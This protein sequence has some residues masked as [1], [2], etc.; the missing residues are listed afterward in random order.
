M[1]LK[2]MILASVVGFSSFAAMADNTLTPSMYTCRGN[3]MSVSY[4]TSSL[5]GRPTMNVAKGTQSLLISDS[6]GSRVYAENT[7][8][9]QL[10]SMFDTRIA[11]ANRSYAL[12]IPG[13]ILGENIMEAK[14]DTML[15]ETFSGGLFAPN[16]AGIRQSNKFYRV[17]CTAAYA[18]F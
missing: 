12:V 11:D 8:M 1:N 17:R 15:I 10:V 6:S 9:G 5:I 4:T 3:G 16:F 14:F 13:I 7:V 2:S 18:V